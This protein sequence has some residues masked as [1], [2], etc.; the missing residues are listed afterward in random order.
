MHAEELLAECDHAL[1][2]FDGPVAWLPSV[3]VAE[4]LRVLV[5]GARLPRR[6]ART[7]DPF[8]L[9]AAQAAGVTAVRY[10]RDDG[11]ESGEPHRNPWFAAL[12]GPVRRLP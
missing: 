8:D 7:A 1:L 11:H 6:V 5:A 9:A 3:A 2:A 12:S 4:R 10:R